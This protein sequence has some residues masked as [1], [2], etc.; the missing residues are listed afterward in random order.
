[1]VAGISSWR[2]QGLGWG[3]GWAEDNTED[4]RRCKSLASQGPSH[5][6]PMLAAASPETGK[7]GAR[8]P[9]TDGLLT[10]SPAR[11]CVRARWDLASA[12]VRAT[13]ASTRQALL[14]P[15]S[16]ELCARVC[17]LLLLTQ[18]RLSLRVSAR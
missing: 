2:V 3:V 11:V 6:T 12:S 5:E 13:G 16:L 14:R 17:L 1:M 9:H 10:A 15:A 18:T 8:G 4:G 7:E